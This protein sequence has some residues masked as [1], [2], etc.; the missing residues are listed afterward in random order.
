MGVYYG[1]I[2]QA[3]SLPFVSL[4]LFYL[5][6]YLLK[7]PLYSQL[8]QEL[9]YANGSVYDQ[10]LILNDK[11]EVDK[12]LLAEQGLVRFHPCDR[13]RLP[14]EESYSLSMLQPGLFNY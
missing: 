3:K 7:L 2:W 11:F 8:S 10:L 9:F 1:N 4:P 13:C 12:T 14:S 5:R 6:D